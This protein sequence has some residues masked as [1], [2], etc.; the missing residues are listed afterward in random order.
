MAT[1]GVVNTVSQPAS[2]GQ[3]V[4]IT[5]AIDEAALYIP[6]MEV[7]QTVEVGSIG[8]DPDGIISKIESVS[9]QFWITPIYPYKSLNV[10]N[11]DGDGALIAGTEIIITI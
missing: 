1:I 6:Q 2:I 8:G 3:S 11:K 7:G 4:L 5:L 10:D 9:G